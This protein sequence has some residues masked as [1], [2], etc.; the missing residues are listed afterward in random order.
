MWRLVQEQPTSYEAVRPPAL[1]VLPTDALWL[2]LSRLAA[3]DLARFAR[4]S[5][6]LRAAAAAPALWSPHC[7]QLWPEDPVPTDASP[8]RYAQR[9]GLFSGVLLC[10]T[11]MAPAAKAVA[12]RHVVAMGGRVESNLTVSVATGAPSATHVLAGDAFT[13][14]AKAARGRTRLLRP[15]WVEHSVAAGA[16]RPLDAYCC[17]LLLGASLT[18]TGLSLQ[19]RAHVA[20]DVERLGGV[21]E[22]ALTRRTTHLLVQAPA[23]VEQAPASIAG[24]SMLVST[25]AV[26]PAP[27]LGS[28]PGSKV[29]VARARGLPV[30]DVGWLA[31]CAAA[32]PNAAVGY[33]G[34]RR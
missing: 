15:E 19:L 33:R 18:S 32:P 34:H 10:C 29:A 25:G 12:H 14:K 3:E 28:E 17:Q 8:A 20:A 1:H 21:Y 23:S 26:N 9:V 11:G 16:L 2:V 24:L 27:A 22:A 13:Q 31:Q 30:L 7:L 4:T 6:A 5:R